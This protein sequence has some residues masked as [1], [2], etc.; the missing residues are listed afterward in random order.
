MTKYKTYRYELLSNMTVVQ[1]NRKK[2]KETNMVV[3]L[4]K[5]EPEQR[6]LGK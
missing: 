4:N 5:S 3:A 2:T 1:E 6:F